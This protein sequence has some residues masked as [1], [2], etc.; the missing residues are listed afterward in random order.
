MSNQP[1]AIRIAHLQAE[2]QKGKGFNLR[3]FSEWRAPAPRARDF[4]FNG[5]ATKI[6]KIGNGDVGRACDSAAPLKGQGERV[7]EKRIH[8][9]F[10][11]DLSRNFID[12]S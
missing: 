1:C 8:V 5:L 9:N 11:N 3:A 2:Q 7:A 6:M 10:I 12:V 4:F